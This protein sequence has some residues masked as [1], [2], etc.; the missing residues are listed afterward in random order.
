MDEN[1]QEKVSTTANIDRRK[2]LRSTATV[3]AG[4]VLNPVTFAQNQGSKADDINVALI[5]LGE[6]CGRLMDAILD[7]E[8]GLAKT[9]GI[10]FKAVCDIFPYRLR[11]I[12][13]R[14]KRAYKHEVTA[15]ESYEEMLAGEKDLDAVIIVTPDWMH[16]P[17]TIASLKEGLHVY[18]EKEMSNSLEDAKKMVQTAKETGKLLQIGHQ[19]RSNPRY[20]VVHKLIRERKII[21]KL[22]NI[23]GQWNRSVEKHQVPLP[24][25]KIWVDD[26]LLKKSGYESME[27]LVNWR[28][29]KKFGGGPLGDLGSHQ[30][31]IFSWFL[32]D[33]NPKSVLAS[34]GNDYY[35][36]EHNENVMAIYEY[37]SDHGSVRAFYQVLNTTFWGTY[38]TYFE[39][40]MGDIG[41]LLI[42]ERIWGE[43]DN[44]GWAFLERYAKDESPEA[45]KRWNDCIR[46]DLIA[47]EYKMPKEVMDKNILKV[48]S[49][50]G[51]REQCYYHP[52]VETCSTHVHQPHLKNFFNA[53][54]GREKLNCPGEVGYE[55][56]VAVLKANEAMEDGKKLIFKPEDFKV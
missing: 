5:G 12:S 40:F 4:L 55:T 49:S 35:N 13:N 44:I 2:F 43:N 26:A 36:Y 42:S 27:Q 46:D 31:D 38:G 52:L 33:Q 11:L 16:A 29:Y 23:N 50:V 22:L 34:G 14:L 19:R 17:M 20:Q 37:E 30:I 24:N 51:G 45:A 28:W 41:T 47:G 6:Q 54:R 10:R 39:T 25:K 21:G 56:A 7:R 9:E 8:A 32:G 15:Y 53:I 48:G 3:G 1:R 18:C